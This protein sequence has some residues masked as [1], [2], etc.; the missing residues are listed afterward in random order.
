VDFSSLPRRCVCTTDL[1][2]DK[3]TA[4]HR[5]VVAWVRTI[6]L[7]VSIT[8]IS[9]K[10]DFRRGGHPFDGLGPSFFPAPRCKGSDC[11]VVSVGQT[12]QSFCRCLAVR[13]SETGQAD[14]GVVVAIGCGMWRTVETRPRLVVAGVEGESIKQAA[15]VKH[16]PFKTYV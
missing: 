8:D 6:F 5:T 12:S 14:K 3:F 7:S 16:S 13:E 2:I 4:E 9:C 11:C 1:T 15:Q 10:R